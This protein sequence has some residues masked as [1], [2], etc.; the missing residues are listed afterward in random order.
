MHMKRMKTLLA[1][2]VILSLIALMGVSCSDDDN[3]GGPDPGDYIEEKEI[4]TEDQMRVKSSLPA[5]V[6]PYE[7]T[8][9]GK[10]FVNRLE[11]QTS[12]FTDEN[13]DEIS[14]VV[15]HSSQI[16][17]SEDHMTLL[18]SQLLMGKNI[19]ILEPT[20]DSFYQFCDI[21]TALYTALYETEEGKEILDELDV[22]PG[23]RQTFEAFY[24]ICNDPKKLDDMFL[25][26]TDSK[27]IF[28]DALAIRGCEFHIVDRINKPANTGSTMEEVNKETGE[29]ITTTPETDTHPSTLDITPYTYGTFADMLVEWVNEQD[30]Y[31]EEYSAMRKRGLYQLNTRGDT[32]KFSLDEICTAQ[33]VEY[34][35]QGYVPHYS[36]R[37]PINVSF[38]ICSVYQEK[39]NCDYYCIY[40]KIKSY[41]QM[42]GC[43]PT[44]TKTWNVTPGYGGYFPIGPFNKWID[45]KHYGPFMSRMTSK[46]M[47][48][49][50]SEDFAE[51]EG[52]VLVM[53]D[54]NKIMPVEGV[55]V[56]EYSPKNS[57]GSTDKSSGFSFG[58][59]GGLSFGADP[60]ASLGIGVSYDA[61]TTQ[62]IEDLMIEASTANE[63][64]EWKYI[65]QNLPVGSAGIYPSH[66]LAPSIMTHECELDQSWIWRVP[67]P[68]GSYRIYDKTEVVTTLHCILDF[69]VYTSDYY[70]FKWTN[71]AVSFRMAPPP[72]CEQ[73][74]MVEVTPYNE[75][76]NNMLATTHAKYWKANNHELDLA[77]S[78]E[79]SRISIQQYMNDFEQ[80]LEDKKKS[81]QNRGLYGLY[82]FTFYKV[83]DP[84]SVYNFTFSAK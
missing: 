45:F 68:S 1:S 15:V 81:W 19:V 61:S 35:M 31:E 47:C 6:F 65:G 73:T 21:V 37:L 27:G 18:M 46:S 66:T 63:V 22:V 26:N 67:N 23:A 57:I 41:N 55:K 33:K 44:D 70:D 17:A 2:G 16:L 50:D 79:E 3:P 52:E 32:Q 62:T 11:N 43:G 28:A 36:T 53:P 69:V 80:D 42:L 39:D 14:T 48:H 58:V 12:S 83:G 34:T 38:E 54:I 24:D 51:M 10:A 40:K 84:E 49:T 72:R 56:M 29:V 82:S 7:Y 8:N 59:D 30:D 64:V 78:T 20:L 9:F 4:I 71:S 13:L 75:K 25:I 77:D 74:W 76:I 5:Y 60:S